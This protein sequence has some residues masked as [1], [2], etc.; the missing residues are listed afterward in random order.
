MSNLPLPA[1]MGAIMFLMLA[2][3]M[4]VV[5][6][7]GA[8]CALAASYKDGEEALYGWHARM[9]NHMLNVLGW[10]AIAGGA[11]AVSVVLSVMWMLA[12]RLGHVMAKVVGM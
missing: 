12:G 2:M 11:I 6:V 8:I 3:T 5:M 4:I 1:Q 10:M 7:L 9:S